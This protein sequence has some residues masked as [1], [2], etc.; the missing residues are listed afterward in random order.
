[1]S[2][3]CCLVPYFFLFLLMKP[4]PPPHPAPLRAS[5]LVVVDL[6]RG[7]ILNPSLLEDL[8]QTEKDTVVG[9]VRDTQG[10]ESSWDGVGG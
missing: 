1:M 4:S 8:G 6:F 5:T 10:E 7:E 9:Q 3:G 2:K